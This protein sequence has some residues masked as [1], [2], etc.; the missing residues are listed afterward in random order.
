MDE[1]PHKL[2]LELAMVIHR[3]MY[4]SVNFFMD[5]EKTFIAWIAKLIRPVNIEDQDYI[6]KEGEEIVEGKPLYSLQGL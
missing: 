2:K 5:K 6:Y 1:L 4:S 3:R